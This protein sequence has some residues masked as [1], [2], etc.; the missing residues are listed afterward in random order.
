MLGGFINDQLKFK[1]YFLKFLLSLSNNLRDF[2]YDRTPTG[3]TVFW[4][5]VFALTPDILKISQKLLCLPILCE[6]LILGIPKSHLTPF[7][8]CQ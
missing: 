1:I 3:G 4:K 5:K 8:I 2:F 6:M 7:N